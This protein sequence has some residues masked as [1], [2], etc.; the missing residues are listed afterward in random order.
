MIGQKLAST[1]ITES[2]ESWFECDQIKISGL[3][4]QRDVED[5]FVITVMMMTGISK[6]RQ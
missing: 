4:I 3:L 5:Y 6:Q 2:K 1:E